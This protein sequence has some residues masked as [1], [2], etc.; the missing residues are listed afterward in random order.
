[1]VSAGEMTLPHAAAPAHLAAALQGLVSVE[2][3]C[4]S[5][6]KTPREPAHLDSGSSVKCGMDDSSASHGSRTSSSCTVSRRSSSS[7]MAFNSST[8]ICCT[9]CL[10][11]RTPSELHNLCDVLHLHSQQH[12]CLPAQLH[13]LGGLQLRP[14]DLLL[15]LSSWPGLFGSTS[16]AALHARHCKLRA[17]SLTNVTDDFVLPK[18]VGHLTPPRYNILPQ[19]SAICAAYVATA[20]SEQQ[21]CLLPVCIAAAGRR[22]HA[23]MVPRAVH[24]V[25][26]AR[27]RCRLPKVLSCCATSASN[28]A[29]Q[30]GT[31]SRNRSTCVKK[32]LGLT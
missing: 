13:V 1:M 27:S 3:F 5:L 15:A 7:T 26:A 23:V 28:A 31:R 19:S 24:A 32:E 11:N 12:H 6:L 21:S 30:A 17:V 18:R 25:K 9:P 2:H 10:Q 14:V 29:E 8:L 20:A 4:A 22:G 16:V